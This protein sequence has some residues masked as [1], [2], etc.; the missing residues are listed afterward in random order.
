MYS[1]TPLGRMRLLNLLPFWSGR[2]DDKEASSRSEPSGLDVLEHQLSCILS[3]DLATVTTED[4]HAL[5]T[6][7]P[8]AAELELAIGKMLDTQ[9][10]GT[11]LHMCSPA[12]LDAAREL[13]DASGRRMAKRALNENVGRLYSI[14]PFISWRSGE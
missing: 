13:V 8:S 1:L 5:R 12:T 11:V 2:R 6:N 4:V 14:L 3:S 10:V 9:R 7:P